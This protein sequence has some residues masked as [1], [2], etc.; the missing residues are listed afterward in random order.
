MYKTLKEIQEELGV[1]LVGLGITSK[2]ILDIDGHSRTIDLIRNI[3]MC[4]DYSIVGTDTYNNPKLEEL[5]GIGFKNSKQVL[6]DWYNKRGKGRHNNCIYPNKQVFDKVIFL[7][8]VLNG[9]AQNTTFLEYKFRYENDRKILKL[10][11]TVSKLQLENE[12][13]KLNIIEK[14]KEIKELQ[15]ICENM[16]K[17]KELFNKTLDNTISILYN[18]RE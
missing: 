18:L 15:H 2:R 14:N 4:T 9:D 7:I 3:Y 6:I 8:D 11:E 13:L 5:K 16:K 12:I 1:D 17:D 10:S